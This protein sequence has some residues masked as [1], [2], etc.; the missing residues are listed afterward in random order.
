MKKFVLEGK[1]RKKEFALKFEGKISTYADESG[2]D[3]LDPPKLPRGCGLKGVQFLC[4]EN[5][6]YCA[7]VPKSGKKECQELLPAKVGAKH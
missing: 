3:G 5:K 6:R 7:P 1:G 2:N 4:K